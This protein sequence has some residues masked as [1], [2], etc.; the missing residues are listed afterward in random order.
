MI[1]IMTVQRDRSRSPKLNNVRCGDQNFFGSTLQRHA[2]GAP[3]RK[4]KMVHGSQT[5]SAA[6]ETTLT[7]NTTGYDGE[8]Q[9]TASVVHGH[10]ARSP[11]AQVLARGTPTGILRA[12]IACYRQ[13]KK[14]CTIAL[15]RSHS[16]KNCRRQNNTGREKE[17]AVY[18]KRKPLARM[19]AGVEL[20]HATPACFDADCELHV[21]A[22]QA[23]QHLSPIDD[24][25]SKRNREKMT[26]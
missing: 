25:T 9:H 8:P 20:D 24:P 6:R 15:D 10:D 18:S 14:D 5:G 21:S 13:G 3:P 23:L 26:G 12:E 7:C 17:E 11:A 19:Q 22:I 1:I 4:D 16:G 2:I